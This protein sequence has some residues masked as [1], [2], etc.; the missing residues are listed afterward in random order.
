MTLEFYA[1]DLSPFTRPVELQLNMK[2]IEY[3]RVVPDRDYVLG[4]EY[5]KLTPLRK[6]PLLVVDGTAIAESRVISDLIED[7]YPSPSLLPDSALNRARARMLCTVVT[8]YI[9]GPAVQIFANQRG[10]NSAD[11]EADARALLVRG[12]DGLEHWI[13]PGPYALGK[14]RTVADCFAAPTLF[15][16]RDILPAMGFGDFPE[17][18]GKTK[19]Y[20]AKVQQDADVAQCLASMDSAMKQRF[21]QA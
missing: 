16:L 1:S 2:G 12:L 17:W 18:G 14:T 6:I 13:K 3:E 5:G 10:R 11:I 19:A 9:A 20:F 21:A 8:L 15:F 4:E 7:L